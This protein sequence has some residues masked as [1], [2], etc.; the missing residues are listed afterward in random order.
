MLQFVPAALKT[1]SDADWVFYQVPFPFCLFAIMFSWADRTYGPDELDLRAYQRYS[2]LG[3]V[4]GT[5]IATV[6]GLRWLGYL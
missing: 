5:G 2:M 6:V 4:A 1:N 3:C